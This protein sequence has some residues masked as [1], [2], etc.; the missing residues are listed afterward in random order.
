[1]PTIFEAHGF[2]FF[3]YSAD[4]A[5][6]I[7]VHVEGSRAFGKW[8]VRRGV[9]AHRRGFSTS[10]LRKVEAELRARKKEIIDAWRTHF[11]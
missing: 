5:E 8:W 1:V 9:W 4:G 7:H 6:P 11:G 3:F 2:R 10:E